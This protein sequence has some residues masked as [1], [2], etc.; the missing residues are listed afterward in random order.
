VSTA[1]HGWRGRA[2]LVAVAGLLFAAI[3]FLPS[4][5]SGIEDSDESWFMQVVARVAS[6]ETLYRDVY[7]NATPL[8]VYLTVGFVKLFGNELL[9]HK[10]FMALLSALIVHLIWL[11]ADQFAALR[12]VSSGLPAPTRRVPLLLLL[13]V[14]VYGIPWKV[15]TTPLATAFFL[16]CQAATLAFLA[17]EQQGSGPGSR[18]SSAYLAL[19]G[20]AAGLSFCSKQNYGLAALGALA[21]CAWVGSRAALMRRRLLDVALVPAAFAAVT[22]LVH[23]PVYLSGG[24]PGLIDYGF[25]NKTQ[26][27]RFASV[28]YTDGIRWLWDSFCWLFSSAH[29]SKHLRGVYWALPFLL[30]FVTFPSLVAAHLF[31]PKDRRASSIAAMLFAAAG[32]VGVFPRCD[33]VHLSFVV[34][35]LLLGLSCAGQGVSLPWP[36][37]PWKLAGRALVFVWLGVGLGLKIVQ[38]AVALLSGERGLSIL[39]HYRG[40]PVVATRDLSWKRKAEA[41]ARASGGAPTFLL[42]PRAGFL[43]LASGIRNPTPFDYPIITGLGLDGEQKLIRALSRGD[44]GVVGIERD[45][46]YLKPKSLTSYVEENLTKTDDLGFLAI[47][48]HLP[49]RSPSHVRDARRQ[50][51]IPS[52]RK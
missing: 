22:I 10:A 6:G 34:P 11:V 52:A 36:G 28:S 45:W 40:T 44:V 33:R 19:A 30:P 49:E 39:P 48:R 12:S 9:V 46:W 1:Q 31:G 2:W 27:V 26:Y 41:L 29:L 23:L 13:G 21:V 5:L 47:Y 18:R 15:T 7:F 24:L 14:F 42:S 38:P 32:F 3:A 25:T 51:A 8:P 20:A 16:G 17:A 37:R 50:C 35:H 4:Y 43:Y